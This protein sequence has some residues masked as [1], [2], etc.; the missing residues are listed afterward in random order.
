MNSKIFYASFTG[1]TRL[2]V[3]RIKRGIEAS[4]HSCELVEIRDIGEEFPE[5]TTKGYDLLGF[6]SPVFGWRE[7]TL[8]R[9]FLTRFP[10]LES[11][12]AFI[13]CTVGSEAG[14]YFYRVEKQLAKKG[15]YAIATILV[16]APSSYVPWNKQVTA[17]D[18]QQL[19]RAEEF[20]RKLF[21]EY[22]AIVVQKK[23]VPLE[24]K[25]SLQGALMGTFAGHDYPLRTLLRKIRVDETKC[26][27]CGICLDNC[28]WGTIT[29]NS[30]ETFPQFHMAKCGGCCACI[31][32]C[33]K[34][35]LSTK[36][37]RGKIRYHEPS[38]KGYKKLKT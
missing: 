26:I 16:N 6:M 21:T 1:N 32:L 25:F 31:A 34:E 37:S 19:A 18:P 14:N 4:G 11:R 36:S 12:P 22:D 8:W 7:P 3:E 38:Y 29:M 28:A 33:P 23:K 35:A 13:G 9:K 24:I 20:G 10:R 27:K 15:I 5:D 17:F 30:K 2:A